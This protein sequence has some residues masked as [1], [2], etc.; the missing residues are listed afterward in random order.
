MKSFLGFA[1]LALFSLGNLAGA[2]QFTTSPVERA[3]RVDSS[4]APGGAVP[5]TSPEPSTLAAL[6]GGAAAA[7][8]IAYRKK[9]KASN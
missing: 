3:A 2:Q 1:L 7:G 4:R 5:V 8:A 6:F 9:R